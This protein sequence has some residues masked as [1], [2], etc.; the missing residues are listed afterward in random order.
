MNK[1]I[2]DKE[3]QLAVCG[4]LERSLIIVLSLVLVV[5]GRVLR[6]ELLNDKS[7]GYFASWVSYSSRV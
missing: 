7:S 3:K 4:G 6:A 1:S 5:M 2:E